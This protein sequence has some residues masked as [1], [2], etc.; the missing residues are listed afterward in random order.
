MADNVE[1]GLGKAGYPCK[2]VEGYQ[3][4]NWILHGLWRYHRSRIR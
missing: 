3:S 2:Q 4:A 1:E